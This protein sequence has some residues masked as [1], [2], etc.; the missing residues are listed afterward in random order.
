MSRLAKPAR[1]G[2]T[3]IEQQHS[4]L[5]ALILIVLSFYLLKNTDEA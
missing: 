5:I 2:E 4:K 1:R 3:L